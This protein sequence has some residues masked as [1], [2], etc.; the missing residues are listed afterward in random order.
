MPRF[1]KKAKFLNFRSLKALLRV[2]EQMFCPNGL[3]YGLVFKAREAVHI[4]I[5]AAFRNAEDE[6]IDKSVGIKH[7]FRGPNFMKF[8]S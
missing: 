1:I 4:G 3:G 8:L 5:F 2:S 6:S 7:F